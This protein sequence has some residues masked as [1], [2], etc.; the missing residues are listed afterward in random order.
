MLLAE[1]LKGLGVK[2]NPEKKVEKKGV[3]DMGGSKSVNAAE[4]ERS[5]FN[6]QSANAVWV[7]AGDCVPKGHRGILK[8]SLVGCRKPLWTL[9]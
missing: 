3:D 2:W 8:Y 7:S 5:N 4:T 9:S 6:N 1:K